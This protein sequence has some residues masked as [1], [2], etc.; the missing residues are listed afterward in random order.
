M[1]YALVATTGYLLLVDLQSRKVLPLE[2][3]RPEYYGISWFPG[4]D[5]LVLSHSGVNNS[6]LVDI[7]SYAQSEKGCLSKGV[8]NSRR[9]LSQ[10]HQIVCTPDGRIICTNTGRNVISVVD[11]NR[12][13]VFQEAGISDARWDRLAL[14]RITGDHLNSVF[15][16]A[17]QLFVMAHG[18]T[19]GSKLAI[20]SY[21][22]LELLSITS[23]GERTGLHNIWITSEGQRISC[24]SEIGSLIDIDSREPLW[25]SG[26]PVYTRG[27][28][29]TRDYVIVGESQKIGRDLR[30]DSLSALWILDRKTWRAIDYF[31]LGSYGAVNEVRL[32]DVPDEAHHGVPLNNLQKFLERC[33]AGDGVQERLRDPEGKGL[34]S[35]HIQG[36]IVQNRLQAASAT[37]EGK[38]AWSSYQLVLGSPEALNDG[39]KR[40]SAGLCLALK[41]ATANQS[42]EHFTYALEAGQVSHVSAV[43]GYTG[44]G[45]DTH[46]AA[47]LVQSSGKEGVLSV[48]LHDGEA[49]KQSSDVAAVFGLPLKGD[50]QLSVTHS[51]AI[52]FVGGVEVLH[53]NAQALG[54]GSCNE[55]LGVRWIGA[56]VKPLD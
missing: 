29:A 22:D 7:S 52:L 9:F 45:G 50:C 30:R 8:K 26:S 19:M 35:A 56:T 46:M 25:E 27:L 48:W 16:R 6:D 37:V 39:S 49:W 42:T 33:I 53:V 15:L 28:A 40:A 20:F 23:L 36:D 24:H 5:E 17:G 31:C 4:E 2:R 1:K 18:H 32:L 11:L 44:K 10:P 13:N 51:T 3:N 12:P 14:D 34:Q 38:I 21:P 47:L 55:G 43:L 54:L 41:H